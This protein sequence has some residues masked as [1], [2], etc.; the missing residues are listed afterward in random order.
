MIFCVPC[1][2]TVAL[3]GDR[4]EGTS[5]G[6]KWAEGVC[7]SQQLPEGCVLPQVRTILSQNTTDTTSKRAFLQL[8]AGF[9]TWTSVQSAGE[10]G[11]PPLRPSAASI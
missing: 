2:C 4:R 5:A 6:S 7:W 8:K 3:S 11:T 10:G 1:A 9:P